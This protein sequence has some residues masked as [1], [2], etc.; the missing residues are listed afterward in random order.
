MGISSSKSKYIRIHNRKYPYQTYAKPPPKDD[1]KKDN[2]N[3][4]IYLD[5]EDVERLEIDFD[6]NDEDYKIMPFEY[7]PVEYDNYDMDE[8]G[9][10]DF[11]EPDK[12]SKD[13][14]RSTITQPQI[15]RAP[16]V[17]PTS[18]VD[19]PST[20][21]TIQPGVKKREKERGTNCH[22]D[23]DMPCHM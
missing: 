10:L 12:Y 1:T 9:N 3:Q 14:T 19:T 18:S 11:T 20:Q 23:M 2:V 22:I 4:Y 6:V 8:Y 15:T 16:I 13:E 21:T 17:K 5:Q 7:K